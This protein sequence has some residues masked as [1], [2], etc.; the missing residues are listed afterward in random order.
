MR[1]HGVCGCMHRDG[2]RRNARV[3]AFAL[4]T[5]VSILNQVLM[6]GGLCIL[7]CNSPLGSLRKHLYQHMQVK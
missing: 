5:N 1:V 4:C 6:F 7:N 3:N 2:E